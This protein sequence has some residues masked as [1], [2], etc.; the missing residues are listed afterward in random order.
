MRVPTRKSEQQRLYNKSTDDV[1]YLT[2]DGL[3]KLKQ[4]IKNIE[5]DL[6]FLRKEV[7]RTAELGDFSENE[8]YKDAKYKLRKANSRLLNAKDRLKRVK[9]IT[10]GNTGGVIHIGST[11][12][13]SDGSKEKT[14]QI[15]G[16]HESNPLEGKISH[17]SP[18]GSV[19]LGKHVGE[20]VIVETK[21]GD[22][23]YKIKNV[24]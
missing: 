7:E 3:K 4:T 11:V 23:E 1:V 6:P 12:T 14:Y 16:S 18:L 13:I 5:S 15:L 10:V 9:V 21:N 2:E 19:L 20:S 24:I 17:V 22:K 8:E